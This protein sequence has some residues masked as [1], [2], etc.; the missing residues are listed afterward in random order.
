MSYFSQIDRTAFT[1]I[2]TDWSN[3]IF[4]VIMPWITH[5]GDTATIWLWIVF[6]GL[7]MGWQLAHSIETDQGRG[8]HRTIMKTVVLFCLYMALIYGVN[9]GVYSGLKHLFHRSRPFMQQ[10]VILRVSS[11]TTSALGDD[12]SFPS[13]HAANA[14][15]VA[16]LLAERLRRKRYYLYS[17]AALVALSRIYL[18]V[19]YPIDVLVGGCLGLSITWLMLCFYPLRKRIARENLF[20]SHN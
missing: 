12:R 20:V 5:I 1:W 9:A 7:L 13:G 8:Q 17:M 6:I 3:P 15:M 14:F 10:T 4:N 11:T 2:N 19:H 18:G 16:A